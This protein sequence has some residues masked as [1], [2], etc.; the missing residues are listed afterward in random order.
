MSV[1]HTAGKHLGSLAMQEQLFTCTG[2]SAM[3]SFRKRLVTLG[4][5]EANT[6]RLHDFRRGHAH[7]LAVRG[8]GG[9]L[10]AILLAGDWRSSSFMDYLNTT[11]LQAK[12]VLEAIADAES[13]SDCELPM[14]PMR[15]AL[16]IK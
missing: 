13:E 9:G 4:I 7:D 6:Y 1:V 2:A 3:V 10:A 14:R 16:R 8:R 12:A 5:P 11:D 15:R